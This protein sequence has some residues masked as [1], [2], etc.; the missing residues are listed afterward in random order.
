MQEVDVLGSISDA[1]I[2]CIHIKKANESTI[3]PKLVARARLLKL[4]KEKKARK[5]R[6]F[7][8]S[9]GTFGLLLSRDHGTTGPSM[10]LGPVLSRPVPGPSRNCPGWNSPAGKPTSHHLNH[11]DTKSLKKS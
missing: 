5:S 4:L 9:P 6:D 10:S 1:T 11:L 8:K 7:K 2:N 3:R